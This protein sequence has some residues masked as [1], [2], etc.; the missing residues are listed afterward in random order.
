MIDGITFIKLISFQGCWDAYWSTNFT[1]CLSLWGSVVISH[2]L[3][4][5]LLK[6]IVGLCLSHNTLNLLLIINTLL[7]II[8]WVCSVPASEECQCLRPGRRELSGLLAKGLGFHLVL[9][10]W[11]RVRLAAP[12]TVPETK[13]TWREWNIPLLRAAQVRLSLLKITRILEKVK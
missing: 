5:A 1:S 3:C 8:W 11:S 7:W 13:S 12:I 6:Y 4:F 9:H 10:V 2:S